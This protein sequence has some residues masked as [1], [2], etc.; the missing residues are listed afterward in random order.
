M[1]PSA[2]ELQYFIEVASTLNVSRAAERLG[3]SQPTLSLA[4]QRLETSFG[5]PLLIRSKSGVRLTQAGQK[6]VTQARGLLLDWEK[7]RGDALKDA[8]EVSG[9]YVIG[10][11]PSVALYSLPHVLPELVEQHQGLDIKLVHDLSRKITEDVVSFKIDF[12]I[13]VNPTEHPD[14]VIKL[15]CTDEVS[16]W[17]ASPARNAD[18]LICDP[19]LLQT[20]S[21]LKQLSALAFCR[22]VWPRAHR[23][24]N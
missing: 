5:L 20:Q 14:L 17:G 24:L 2:A 9:R 7:I 8:S 21:L 11:H 15:L 16:V 12:G 18:V 13:V 19:E 3:I 4:I 1:L 10:C 22:R 23:R 6:L